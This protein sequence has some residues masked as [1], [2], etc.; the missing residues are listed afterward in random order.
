MASA[1][2]STAHMQ[3]CLCDACIMEC[4]ENNRT[5]HLRHKQSSDIFWNVL[6]KKCFI[7]CF[8]CLA[9]LI[10]QCCMVHYKIQDYT[11]Q[12]LNVCGWKGVHCRHCTGHCCMFSISEYTEEVHRL[13]CQAFHRWHCKIVNLQQTNICMR[14]ASYVHSSATNAGDTLFP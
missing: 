14:L 5:T 1:L 4:Y 8:H 11:T 7:Q 13:F 10:L 12:P 2:P 9:Q 6:V 3:T